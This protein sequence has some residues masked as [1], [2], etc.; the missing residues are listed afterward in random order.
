MITYVPTSKATVALTLSD[1]LWGLT[2]PPAIRDAKD[3]ARM[4][5]ARTMTDGSVWLVVDTEFTIP[6]HALADVTPIAEILEPF[7]E[8]GAIEYYGLIELFDLIEVTRGQS[9]NVWESFPQYWMGLAH[10]EE[11]LRTLNLWPV[12][13]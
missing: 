1:A 11:D 2:R 7:V 13:L 8:V 12:Q 5:G 9:L 10:D 4:F 6:V 3:T